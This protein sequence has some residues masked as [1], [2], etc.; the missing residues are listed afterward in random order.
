[1]T[2]AQMNAQVNSAASAPD[3]GTVAPT[4]AATIEAKIREGLAPS[5][6][7]VSNESGNHNVPKGSESHFKLV[8]VSEKFEGQRTLHRH[9]MVYAILERE[10]AGSV[11]A[12]ALHTYTDEQWREIDDAPDSPNCH[13]GMKVEAE[14][15]NKV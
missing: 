15:A 9:R 4:M 1:M 3:A 10:L 6:L 11:H 14:I 2:T 13:G 12:L 8:I 7:E 5:H